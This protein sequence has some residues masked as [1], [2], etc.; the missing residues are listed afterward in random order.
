MHV[1]TLAAFLLALAVVVTVAYFTQQNTELLSAE[2]RL[3][4]ERSVPLYA[5]FLGVF[6]LGFLPVV[7][8][9]VVQTL[10]KE[11]SDRRERRR[12]REA[13][14]RRGAFRRAVDLQSDGQWR[15]SSAELE[16][17]LADKPEEYGTLLRYG[18]ALRLGD[19][20]EE[21][22]E[23]HRKASVLYPNSVALLY[24]LAADYEAL[25]QQQVAREIQDRVLRDYPGFGLEILRRRRGEALG[26]EEWNEASRLQARI[27]AILEENGSTVE[28]ERQGGLALGLAYQRG[29]ALLEEDSVEE[30]EE[31]FA[32]VL[33]EEPR[34]VAAAIMLGEAA[35]GRSQTDRALEIWC[36]GFE[37][38]GSPVFLQRIEDHFIER[39]QPARAIESLI[40]LISE[41][42]NDLLPRFFLGRLYYRLEMHEEAQRVL[43][44]IA[45]RI[46]F[47]PTFHLLL[48]RIYER[49]GEMQ[50]AVESYFQ[51]VR[52]AGILD[53]EYRCRLCSAKSEGWRDR[54]TACGA[55]SS[56]ELDFQEEAVSAE[57]LG[58]PPM[59]VW[60][61]EEGSEP[62]AG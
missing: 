23:V 31:V 42:S 62:E 32:E 46:G 9:L 33:A 8:V 45:E 16:L 14:S 13:N 43:S 35:L 25:G 24:Q 27:V 29:V 41:S 44:G 61:V 54:C 52:Q 12:R 47:S 30:A 57:E 3:D 56:V 2:F 11:L 39:E 36:R 59:A 6:L 51:C 1:R 60:A 50:K 20:A 21:A 17:T 19:R 15:R 28:L 5:A 58:L 53:R 4:D 37:T 34:F 18:E 38:T 40:Q 49:R 26:R 48:A 22:V 7:T 55:W 10:K